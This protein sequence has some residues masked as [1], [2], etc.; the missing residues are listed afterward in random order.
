MANRMTIPY[1]V[2]KDQFN[3][4]LL[5]WFSSLPILRPVYDVFFATYRASGMFSESHFL[6]L[7]QAVESFDRRITGGRYLPAADY[8]DFYKTLVAAIPATAPAA[9]RQKL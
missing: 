5:N 3:T 7:V 4:T 2:I 8:E 9:L 1:K 6:H